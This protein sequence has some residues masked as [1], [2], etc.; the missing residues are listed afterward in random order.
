M[1]T[2]REALQGIDGLMMVIDASQVTHQDRELAADMAG[3]KVRKTLVLNKID[4]VP[5]ENLLALI[6]SFAELPYDEV[7][8]ISARTGDGVEELRSVLIRMLQN[9]CGENKTYCNLLDGKWVNPSSGVYIEILS[10]VDGSLVGRVPAM[11]NLDYTLTVNGQYLDDP[12]LLMKAQA[13]SYQGFASLYE[14]MYDVGT[15][16]PIVNSFHFDTVLEADSQ[17]NTSLMALKKEMYVKCMMA[18][19]EECLSLY[20]ELLANYMAQGGQ[21]VMDEKIAAWDA[22]NP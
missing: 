7:V 13:T 22:M 16:D 20:Q 3:Q 9:L 11:Q 21:A 1:Q 4:M 5:K 2:V 8:P 12:S 10:P 6:Q 19:P 17:Y 18:K 14:E 15:T